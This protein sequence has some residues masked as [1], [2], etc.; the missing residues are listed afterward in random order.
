MSDSV[1]VSYIAA[2][3]FVSRLLQ[4]LVRTRS[5]EVTAAVVV[6]TVHSERCTELRGI[7][8]KLEQAMM[9]LLLSHLLDCDTVVT[10]VPGTI[11]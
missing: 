1:P 7:T 3:M 8:L 2:L 9:I 6:V 11:A 10:S 5:P 4:A